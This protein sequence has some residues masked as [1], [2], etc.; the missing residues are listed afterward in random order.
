MT[1]ATG[2]G[3]VDHWTWA[4]QKGVMN[5]NTANGIRAACSNVMGVLD[6]WESQDIKKLDVE[7]TLV[8]FQ[9]LKKKEFKPVVLETYKRRFRLAVTSYLSYL[10]DPSGWKPTTIRR[11][12]AGEKENGEKRSAES[13]HSPKHELPQVNMVEYPFPLREGQSVRLVLPRDLKT[14]EVKRLTA[15]MSTLAIDFDPS[16]AG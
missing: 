13:A 2:K 1:E 6:D 7:S 15:F 8:R 11:A 14:A 4:S 5:K 16:A 10:E 12:V 9:N 3:L